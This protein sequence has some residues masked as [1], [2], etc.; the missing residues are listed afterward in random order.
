[1]AC[2]LQRRPADGVRAHRGGHRE[3]Q[4][5]R[6]HRVRPLCIDAVRAHA[7]HG[8][9]VLPQ[10]DGASRACRRA[11]PRTRARPH[12]CAVLVAQRQAGRPGGTRQWRSH[13]APRAC[14]TRCRRCRAGH[15]ARGVGTLPCTPYQSAWSCVVAPG[16]TRSEALPQAGA[17][18]IAGRGDSLPDGLWQGKTAEGSHPWRSLSRIIDFGFAATDF[19]AYD[20]AVAVNDWCSDAH[21]N[22]VPEWTHAF[23]AAYAGVRSPTAEERT[24]WAAL[25]RAAALRFWLSRLYD[26]H[27]PRSGELT[28]THDPAEFERIL[29]ARAD[30]MPRFPDIGPVTVPPEGLPAA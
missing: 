13:R 24:Q 6:H 28:H 29:R 3:H 2:P 27:L 7:G 11:R 8:A 18:R 23:V 20:L 4:L 30:A 25:L 12:R 5:L 9:A 17:E 22:L 15:A 10:P 16:R 14:A 19:Y 21:G 1:M 26:L